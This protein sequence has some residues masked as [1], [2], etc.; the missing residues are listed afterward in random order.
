MAIGD[1]YANWSVP[2]SDAPHPGAQLKLN[3]DSL[4]QN[5]KGYLSGISSVFMD[6]AAAIDTALR[7]GK[8]VVK[9]YKD[10]AM[11]W[12]GRFTKATK[13]DFL[14]ILMTNWVNH[15]F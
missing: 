15:I 5:T 2:I 7:D 14:L 10:N 13:G 6:E 8:D 1:F 3:A 4:F 9:V 11:S 12:L